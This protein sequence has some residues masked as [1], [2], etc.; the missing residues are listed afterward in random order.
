MGAHSG[1]FYTASGAIN[2]VSVSLLELVN[3]A[4]TC[5]VMDN[6]PNILV[7]SNN[8]LLDTDLNQHESLIQPHQ[9]RAIGVIGDDCARYHLGNNG[10]HGGQCVKIDTVT[11]YLHFDG[12]NFYFICKLC[13]SLQTLQV[14]ELTSPS[15]YNL[16]P[17]S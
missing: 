4:V 3:E 5:S 16:Q 15:P 8:C 10:N 1:I 14:Y 6:G 11:L 12:W 2:S 7:K 9:S 17:T 13:S